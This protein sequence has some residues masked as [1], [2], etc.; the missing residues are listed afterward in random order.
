M[1]LLVLLGTTILLTT[2]GPGGTKITGGMLVTGDVFDSPS[3]PGVRSAEV[4]INQ[5]E[6]PLTRDPQQQP[7]YL[8]FEKQ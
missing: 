1:I 8:K 5:D 7:A 4:S 3:C 2:P 6:P